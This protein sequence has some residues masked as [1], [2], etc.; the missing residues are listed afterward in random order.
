MREFDALCKRHQFQEEVKD[1]RAA[2]TPWTLSCRWRPENTSAP[3]L[4]D[5]MREYMPWGRD[6]KRR[7]QGPEEMQQ[8][9]MALNAAY[10]GE[11]IELCS[12]TQ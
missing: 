2:L 12:E 11:V 6:G 9:L 10:G 8:V 7:K 5:W 3:T 1:I 4:G